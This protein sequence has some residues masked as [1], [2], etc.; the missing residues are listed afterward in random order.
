MVARILPWARMRIESAGGK[1]LPLYQPQPI[2]TSKVEFD[3]LLPLAELLARNAHEIWAELRMKDGWTYGPIRDDAG[4]RH[5][6]L[7]PFDEM[8]ATDQAFDRAMIFET[9]KAAIASGFGTR[10]PLSL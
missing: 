7:V 4:K 10:F 9:L 8:S 2:D 6:C 1:A 3:G 5:P